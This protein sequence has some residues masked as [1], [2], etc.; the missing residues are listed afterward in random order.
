MATDVAEFLG[1]AL[2]L[3]LLF[4]VPLL[5]AALL[6]AV[7]V[8][9]IL[10]LYRYGFRAVEM[11][12]ISLVA[13]VGGA[14]ALEVGLVQPDWA[15]VTRGALL[16]HLPEGGL[17]LAMGIVGATVMPH[18]LYLH[19][20]VILS[21]RRADPRRNA[22]AVRAAL[23]DSA[24]A[25][26]LAWLVNSAIV[27]MAAAFFSRGLASD[28]IEDAHQTLSPLLGDFAAGAFAVAL[29]A[30]G[31]ASSTTA[32][33]AGQ[34]IVEGF[35][36]LRCPLLLR[37]LVTVVP[38]LVVIAAGWDAYQ[39]LIVSQVALSVQLPF[40]VAPLVWLT[41][42]QQVMRPH[43]NSRWTTALAVLVLVALVALNLLLL[44]GLLL[45]QG[46]QPI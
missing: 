2:G 11:A 44:R 6:T 27:V 31:L 36:N 16:P 46:F 17:V 32:T 29:L 1:A 8:F 9:G 19:S 3:Y 4:H 20:G 15:A 13:V 33:L 35:L 24:V 41:A 37:R 26:N 42:R 34:I 22:T 28:A 43:A 45:D 21:R 5:P 23:A 38:A 39:V 25:L 12:I 14:Y 7:A 40:A 30:A 10:A 18:N